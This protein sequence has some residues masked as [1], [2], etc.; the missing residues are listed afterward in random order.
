MDH[1]LYAC[2]YTHIDSIYIYTVMCVA[3]TLLWRQPHVACGIRHRVG[4]AIHR[5]YDDDR[6]C[7][8]KQI[9]TGIHDRTVAG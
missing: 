2:S 5:G 3:G 4:M 9:C 8:E 6:N 7:R 1:M